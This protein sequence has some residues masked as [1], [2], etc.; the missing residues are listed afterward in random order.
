MWNKHRDSAIQ[1]CPLHTS[2]GARGKVSKVRG[3]S[4]HGTSR[5]SRGGSLLAGHA[6]KP[7][8]EA[9]VGTC[10]GKQNGDETSYLPEFPKPQ[11]H[12]TFSSGEAGFCRGNCWCRAEGS[13]AGSHLPRLV[14]P[15]RCVR[16]GGSVPGAAVAVAVSSRRRARYCDTRA[17]AS[18][19]SAIRTACHRA[20]L[21]L[22]LCSLCGCRVAAKL[23]G[24]GAN[25][26]PLARGR[27]GRVHEASTTEQA[28]LGQGYA[29]HTGVRHVHPLR[30][31]G[32]PP[33]IADNI[34]GLRASRKSGGEPA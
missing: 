7:S 16:Q 11:A 12:P 3:A 17:L 8:A 1:R 15:R 14:P 23:R 19:C 34:S 27:L 9:S 4:G 32:H 10:H 6:R 5:P 2:L 29:S 18:S 25:Q 24:R 31:P 33:C 21:A 28:Q 26:H 20:V 22:P 13:L 30:R